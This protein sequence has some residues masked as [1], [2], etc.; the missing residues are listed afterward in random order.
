MLLVRAFDVSDGERHHHPV[1]MTRGL[2]VHRVDQIEGVLR[3]VSLIGFG[4]DPDG[5]E[6]CAQISA[7]RLVQ[8]D[9]AYVVGI[10]RAD[11]EV[12]VEEALRRVSVRI[13]D[14]G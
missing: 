14:Q 7:T 6:F 9:V 5:K 8:T 12:F 2:L 11:I 3:E 13:D 4:F 10:S 1:G